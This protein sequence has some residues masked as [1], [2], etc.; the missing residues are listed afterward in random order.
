MIRRLL[1]DFGGRIAGLKDSSGDLPFARA[2]A[3]IAPGFKVFPSNE[4]VLTEA[5]GGRFAGCISA[6]TNLNADLC[7]RAFHGGNTSALVAAVTIRGLFDGKQLVSRGEGTAGPH[8]RRS[9]LGPGE[10]AA[11]AVPG[12][13]SGVR[14]GRLRQDPRGRRLISTDRGCFDSADARY[15]KRRNLMATPSPPLHSTRDSMANTSSAK[16]AQRVIARR[17][18]VN[19]ARRSRMR[20]YVGKVEEA[21]AAGDRDQ[22]LQALKDAEPIL[23]RSAQKG[24]VHRNA[25]SRKVSRLTGQIAKLG[26]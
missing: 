5:R 10:T 8:S 25:A 21:I 4:G 11:G 3:E 7:A 2:A 19:K 24:I 17:T 13:R 6:T 9:G 16:K 23:I 22:A 18:E 20:S 26:K 15:Y 12:G 1:A 14:G